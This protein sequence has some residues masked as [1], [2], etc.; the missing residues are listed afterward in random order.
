MGGMTRTS[1]RRRSRKLL[2]RSG[3]VPLPPSDLDEAAARFWRTT[4]EPA[5]HLT[6]ADGPA[7]AECCR[8]YSLHRRASDEYA[9]K[10]SNRAAGTAGRFFKMWV[11]LVELLLLHPAGRRAAEKATVREADADP[12]QDF[13]P[14]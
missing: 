8:L 3:D 2:L 5:A 11:G 4:I 9:R 12:S 1:G 10:P 7:A 14:N 13:F 6:S